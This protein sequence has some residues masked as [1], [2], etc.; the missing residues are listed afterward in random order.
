MKIVLLFTEYVNACY[1]KK[2][3]PCYIRID[4]AHFMHKYAILLKDLTLR[5]KKFFMV[6]IGQL[7]LSR[8][9]QQA[10]EI[11]KHILTACQAESHGYS[12]ENELTQCSRSI[13]FLKE[14]ATS[15]T[16]DDFVENAIEKATAGYIS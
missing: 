8:S 2:S 9:V 15:G 5:L 13:E 4:V 14:L 10:Q 12:D 3:V 6:A 16:K 11:L 7:V 1:S